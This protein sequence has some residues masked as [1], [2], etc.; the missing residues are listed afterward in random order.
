MSSDKPAL[1]GSEEPPEPSKRRPQRIESTPDSDIE[2]AAPVLHGN[3]SAVPHKPC[4]NT[5]HR[6]GRNSLHGIGVVTA[7]QV[8]IA[9]NAEHA[10]QNILAIDFVE[11]NIIGNRQSGS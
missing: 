11:H 3:L 8:L 6:I 2:S 4:Q 7:D 1:S 10:M 5:D 9:V